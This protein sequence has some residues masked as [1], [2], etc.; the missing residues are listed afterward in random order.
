MRIDTAPLVDRRQIA[1]RLGVGIATVDKWRVRGI[2]PPP[3]FPD[4]AVPIWE[5]ETI[6][7]WAEQTG[8]L[9]A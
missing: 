2:L 3:D 8:R 5:W 4:L 6:R 7:A 9:P 1:E